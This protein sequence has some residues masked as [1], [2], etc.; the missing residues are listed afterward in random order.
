MSSP[1]FSFPWPPLAPNQPPPTWDGTA[2]R[3]GGERVQVLEYS[4]NESAWDAELTGFHEEAASSHH[5]IDLA[6]RSQAVRALKAFLPDDAT[7]ILEVGSSSG[8]LLPLLRDAFPRSCVIG[9]DAF[10]EALRDLAE[11]SQGLPLLQFDLARCPLPDACLDGVVALNVLE[12]VQ[13]DAAGVREMQRVLKPGGIAYLEVPAGAWLYDIYDET[14]RH[15]RRYSASGLRRLVREAGF[16]VER[17]S[18]LGFLVFPAFVAAKKRNQRLLARSPEKKRSEVAR[19]ISATR[20]SAA[21]A[22]AFRTDSW[23]SRLVTFPIGIRCVCVLRKPPAA[24]AS[25]SYPLPRPG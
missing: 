23:L 11:R 2:F 22:A 4:R 17:F 12:H 7:Y 16:R 13:D 15:Y 9:S 14:L 8:F 25:R 6:S 3:I 10:P 18:H 24:S 20:R 1:R 19:N 5:P 21:L